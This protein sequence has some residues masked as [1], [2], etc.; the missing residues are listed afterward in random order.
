MFGGNGFF[1]KRV[2]P[3]LLAMVLGTGLHYVW[4]GE[5]AQGCVQI[6]TA[7]YLGCQ[8][9]AQRT[10][11][12]PKWALALMIAQTVLMV[13]GFV[14]LVNTK[15]YLGAFANAVVII[16]GLVTMFAYYEEEKK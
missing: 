5:Y 3:I 10:G 14:Y 7:V 8:F 4:D 6:L 12:I 9:L 16:G 15:E 13:V 1:E 11:F 2:V